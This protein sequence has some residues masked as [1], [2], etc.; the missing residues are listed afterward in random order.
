MRAYERLIKYAKYEAAS[1]RAATAARTPEQLE[2]G[3]AL[4]RR[5]EASASR[6]PIWMK[7]AM[8]SAPSRPTS[9]VEGPVVGFIAHMDVVRDVPYQGIKPR[10]VENYSGGDIILNQSILL[11]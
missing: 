6:M 1:D 3:R 5:C 11:F 2:F 4:P 8:S 7:T 10:V 9:R